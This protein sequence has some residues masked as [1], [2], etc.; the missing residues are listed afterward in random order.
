[1][2]PPNPLCAERARPADKA[3]AECGLKLRD[4]V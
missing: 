3:A 4:Q 2:V 1:M